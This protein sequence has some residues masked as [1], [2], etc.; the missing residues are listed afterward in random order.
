MSS[1]T[2]APIAARLPVDERRGHARPTVSIVIVNFNGERDLPTCLDSINELGYPKE[3]IE[4]IVVDNGSVDG[5]RR[6]LQERYPAARV[7][8]QETN[9]G[10]APAVNL[11]VQG[12]SGELVALLNNDMHV[13]PGW[14]DALVDAWDPD[15]GYD[16]VAG[17]ILDWNGDR[18]DFAEGVVNWHGM[19]DQVGFGKPVEQVAIEDGR[20]LLFA[21][22]G[23]MLVTRSVFLELGGLDPDYFAYYEDIDFGW[24]LWLSGRKVRL[25]AD[26]VSFHRHNGT[27]GRFPFYQRALLYERNALRTLIK[28]L[29]DAN[30]DRVLGPA[31]LLLVK[32]ALGESE[33]DRYHYAF[34]AE[35]TDD[36]TETVP[37]ALMAR[38][39]AI[40]D[41]LDGLDGL[42]QERRRVQLTRKVGDAVILQKF[43]HPFR[44]IGV[45]GETYLRAAET[46]RRQFR[47]DELFERE[48]ASRVFVLA[49]DAIREKMA[50]PAVRSWEI[51]KAMS[52]HCETI[53]VSDAPFERSA[54]GVQTHTLTGGD[55][56]LHQLLTETD[57]VLVQGYAL[58]KYPSLRHTR[59]LLVVDLYDPWLL[60]NLEMHRDTPLEVAGDFA[61]RH[62]VDVQTQLLD[63]GDYFICASERQRDYW[64]GMLS[65]RGRVNRVAYEGDRSLRSLVDVVPYG[66]PET[67][68]D[69]STPRLKGVVPGIEQDDI[70]LIWTG[71]TWEWFDPLLVL[72]AF[73]RAR[74]REPRL[75]LYFMGL[76]QA[77]AAGVPQ[78]QVAKD[79]RAR[80]EAA[81]LVDSAVFF[82]NWAPYDDRGSYLSEA[83]IAVL[84]TKDLAEVRLAF[85][86]RILDHFWAGLP[87]VTTSG[88]VLSD[89]IRADEAG[90]VTPIGDVDAF[91]DALLVLASDD[92]RRS[93]MSANASAV[94][95]RYG[96]STAISPLA[97]VLDNPSKWHAMRAE[98]RKAR[99]TELRED[100]QVLLIHRRGMIDQYSSL[101]RKVDKLKRSPLG[102]FAKFAWKVARR[103]RRVA[104]RN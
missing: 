58:L 57:V 4:V 37:R 20:E 60:E 31:L 78:M 88:D 67:P 19:G 41:L 79:L 83:D 14:L 89:V 32:R 12:A 30:L 11:G 21:C 1:S 56:E 34:G 36:S 77:S 46:V 71:G 94:A 17:T 86:S 38:L 98:R 48:K 47:I 26:A 22:G 73:M 39:H 49:Y 33:S 28:N 95:R 91:A 15:Q 74:A 43:G 100:T 61:I 40:S 64:L 10:F 93:R 62:D 63:H 92:D 6:L 35:G 24:R 76:D 87:T 25:A 72:D 7:L 23:A 96:W 103:V 5:S 68:I 81:G 80:A 53:V 85:R 70:L 65:A 44:P 42:M 51:A 54:E 75:K 102:P 13:Q 3:Q 99:Q 82:G 59:A 2:P 90:I 97:R 45:G 101:A 66:A 104:R 8:A 9:L 18:I 52:R 84:A 50:G 16:C 69:T 55:E 29:D 27:S